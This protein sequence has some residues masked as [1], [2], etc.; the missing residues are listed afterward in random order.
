[1]ALMNEILVARKALEAYL[2]ISA[3]GTSVMIMGRSSG[4]YSSS[5]VMATCWVGAPMTMR[6]GRKRVLDGRA[7]AEELRVGDDVEGHG[8]GLVALDDLAHELAGAHGHRRL[9]HHHRVALHGLA[10]ARVAT[11]STALRSVLP[12]SLGRR[13]PP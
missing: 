4:A 8:R 13:R 3:D 10:D 12:P 11:A 2:I 7:L 9:V 1:M 5:R 6:S